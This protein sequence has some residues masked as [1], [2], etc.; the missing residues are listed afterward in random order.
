M[1]DVRKKLSEEAIRLSLPR[2][3]EDLEL[4]IALE[5]ATSPMQDANQKYENTRLTRA[6]ELVIANGLE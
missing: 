2:S 1:I 3:K 5:T 4:M 6:I